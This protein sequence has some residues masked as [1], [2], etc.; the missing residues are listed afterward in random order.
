MTALDLA[1]GGMSELCG[2][3]RPELACLGELAAPLVTVVGVV[4]QVGVGRGVDALGD[5]T[6]A[7]DVLAAA[8]PGTDPAVVGRVLDFLR[9]R[10]DGPAPQPGAIAAAGA[11]RRPVTLA[12]AV[13]RYCAT[14]LRLMSVASQRGYRPWLTRLVDAHGDDDPA[15]VTA[16]DL[17]DLISGF[18]LATR[19]RGHAGRRT[20]EQ[21]VTAY[22]AFWTYLGDKRWATE[23]VAMRLRKPTRVENSRR[24]WKPEE[25]AVAR[26][27]ARGYLR[28]DPLL[29]EVTLC[30]PERMGL[31][32][33]E[34][35]GLRM[36]DIDWDAA[37]AK[38]M[39]KG[40]KPRKVPIPPVFFSVLVTYVEQ[41]RPAGIAPEAWLRSDAQVLRYK[42]TARFP[43]GRP[44]AWRRVDRLMGSV[45]KAAP[46]LFPADELCLHTHRNALANW[47]E[48]TYTRTMAR[49]ALGHTSK[50]DPTDSY[51]GVTF[52]QLTEALTAYEQ[53]MLAADPHHGTDTQAIDVT[54]EEAA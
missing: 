23:N 43:Q 49:R 36:C 24:G 2:R 31:R 5:P 12:E 22:R 7:L 21:A 35:V 10:I 33:S 52:E 18:V 6:F 37:V 53:Y 11:A 9:A 25:A 48:M 45:R 34:Y 1:V 39:G 27:L 40:G 50:Q 3:A 51:L 17:K 47:C 14:A 20:E 13:E 4:E 26:H 54:E 41:R 44:A 29:N 16:G 38:V 32:R 8:G 30:F 42:P 19:E 46:E 15:M 28:T